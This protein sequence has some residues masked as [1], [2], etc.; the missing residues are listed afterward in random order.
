M[1]ITTEQLKHI[2]PKQSISVLTKYVPYL[3][4]YFAKYEV[5]TALRIQHFL[6]QIAVESEEF[7]YTKE[8][9]S[10]RAYEGRK[11]LGNINPGDGVKFKGRGLIQITGRLNYIAISKFIFNDERLL[12]HPELLETPEYATVS[13]I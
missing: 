7:V 13:A 12:D 8:L 11:D 3:N 5:N 10:G 1:N 6:A 2:C 4:T 9:A